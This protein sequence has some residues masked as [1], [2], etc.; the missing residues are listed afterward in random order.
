MAFWGS[1]MKTLEIWRKKSL[2]CQECNNNLLWGL[3][4]Y[5]LSLLFGIISN[6]HNSCKNSAKNIFI[7]FT[8]ICLLLTFCPI[9]F[10]IPPCPCMC[11]FVSLCVCVVLVP[12]IYILVLILLNGPITSFVATFY[13]LVIG[14][15]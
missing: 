6:L 1:Y 4:D 15:V 2:D 14:S 9:C 7:P 3:K 11:V 12:L 5:F 13:L 8:Q 10:I